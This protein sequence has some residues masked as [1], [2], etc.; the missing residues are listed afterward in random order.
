VYDRGGI[1]RL[2]PQPLTHAIVSIT[3]A[4]DDQATVP[5][6]GT[7]AGVLRLSFLDVDVVVPRVREEDLFSEE[8]ARRLW[9]FVLRHRDVERLLVHCDAGTSRA[10]AIAAAVAKVFEGDDERFFSTYTPN[11]RVYRTL[12]DVYEAEYT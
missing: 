8:Q 5:E 1:E 6:G 2:A 9:D 10:P 11:R 4:P 12:L 7:C 3:S